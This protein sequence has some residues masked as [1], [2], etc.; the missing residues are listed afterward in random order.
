MEL[1]LIYREYSTLKFIQDTKF[2]YKEYEK[3]LEKEE[4]AEMKKL[5]VPYCE[6]TLHILAS[7][8]V[9]IKYAMPLVS[10]LFLF[11]SIYLFITVS[12]LSAISFFILKKRHR[13]RQ[14]EYSLEITALNDF[15][16]EKYHT[17]IDVDFDYL[18]RQYLQSL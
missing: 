11:L 4:Y 6:E 13:L 9:L 10:V 1:R 14:W 5:F 17:C 16:N 3:L 8:M 15:I 12:A 2:S 7:Y 18:G